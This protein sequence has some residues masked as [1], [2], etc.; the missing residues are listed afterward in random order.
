MSRSSVPPTLA[1]RE[2][3]STALGALSRATGRS[4]AAVR[5]VASL[6]TGPL[7]ALE[8]ETLRLVRSAQCLQR[9]D[10]R[11]LE[12]CLRELALR[13]SGSAVYIPAREVAAA[14]REDAR[15]FQVLAREARCLQRPAL[16]ALSRQAAAL[17]DLVEVTP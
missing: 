2:N 14:L 12:D 16:A 5:R 7:R 9:D 3:I 15:A 8:A 13:A 11:L 10:L 17:A 4:G 1:A 6:V